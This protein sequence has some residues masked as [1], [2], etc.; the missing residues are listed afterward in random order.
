MS[1][2]NEPVK[3][4]NLFCQ[5]MVVGVENAGKDNEKRVGYG[6]SDPY[7]TAFTHTGELYRACVKQF[8]RCTG[9]MYADPNARKIGWVFLKKVNKGLQEM[10]L[11]E[12]WVEVFSKPP[13]RTYSWS[14]PEYPTFKSAK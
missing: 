9:A 13:V 8:G 11:R 5:E 12:T 4:T 14:Q 1:N 2:P 7:E 3:R 10:W 6:T